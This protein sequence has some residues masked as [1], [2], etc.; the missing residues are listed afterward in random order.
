MYTLTCPF[1]YII[2]GFKS[3]TAIGVRQR[4]L[5]SIHV[6]AFASQALPTVIGAARYDF[7]STEYHDQRVFRPDA[8][9]A[10]FFIGVVGPISQPVL[11]IWRLWSDGSKLTSEDDARKM[12]VLWHCMEAFL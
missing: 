12:F 3:T 2:F 9:G 4:T 8:P 11:E 5:H 10:H 6:A 7:R 1:L